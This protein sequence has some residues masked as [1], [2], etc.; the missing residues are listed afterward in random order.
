MAELKRILPTKEENIEITKISEAIQ[1]IIFGNAFAFR[2]PKKTKKHKKQ[3]MC[4]GPKTHHG[5]KLDI[6]HQVLLL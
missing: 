3:K 5:A 1:E 2:Q 4:L 6:T